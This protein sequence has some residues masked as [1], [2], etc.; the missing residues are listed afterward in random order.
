[1]KEILDNNKVNY[2]I[3]SSLFFLLIFSLNPSLN[4]IVSDL[5]HWSTYNRDDIAFVYN[6]LLYLEGHEIHHTD[7][8]SVFTFLIFPFFYKIAFYLGYIDFYNLTGFLKSDDINISL[9][10]LFYISR[11]VIQIFSIGLIITVYKIVNY[12]SSNKM[13]SLFITSLFIISTGFV[14]ASNRIESG[15]ISIFFIFLALYFFLKFLTKENKISIIYFSLS[16]LFIFSGMMQKKVVYFIV[17]FLFLASVMI[18]KKKEV[19]Y[20][21]YKIL[22]YK[23]VYKFF[24]AFLYFIVFVFFYLKTI[25]NNSI[26]NSRDL[27]FIFLLINFIIFNLL[28]IFYIRKFQNRYYENLLTYNLLII[29]IYFLYQFFLVY[30]FSVSNE[31]WT[32]TFTNFFNHINA[33]TSLEEVKGSS[34]FSSVNIYV[35]KFIEN[36]NSVIHKYFLSLNYQSILIWINIS[37]FLIFLKKNF[38]KKKISFIILLFGFLICQSIILFR[39]EQNTYYLNTECFLLFSLSIVIYNIKNKLIYLSFCT[40]LFT[41]LFYSN[42]KTLNKIKNEN[43]YSYCFVFKDFNSTNNFYEVFTNK[44]PI[45][46]RKNFCNDIIL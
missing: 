43:S 42:I 20:L 28:F 5:K 34:S 33:F 38:F 24:L 18:A 35:L 2:L 44:I 36:L 6:S 3:L 31:V 4:F 25:D 37:L 11:L 46:I 45:E 15:L 21:K 26:N 7:H 12:F 23:S 32:I 17:P 10:K 19:I 9:S 39:Y 16:I 1:M 13:D 40:I 8:P 41:V 29:A 22:N 14:S 27:D 30:V